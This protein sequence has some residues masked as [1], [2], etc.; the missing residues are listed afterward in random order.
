ML[1]ILSSSIYSSNSGINASVNVECP[2]ALK[3]NTYPIYTNIPNQIANFTIHSTVNCSISNLSG[4]F[5]MIADNGTSVY[6]L[7]I[8]KINESQIPLYYNLIFNPSNIPAGTYKTNLTFSYMH[9]TNSSYSQFLLNNQKNISILKFYTNPSIIINSIQTFYISLNNTGSYAVPNSISLSI[10]ITGPSHAFMR[11]PSNYSL[12]PSQTLNLSIAMYN[13]TPITGTYDALLNLSYIITENGKNYLKSEYEL[14]TYNVVSRSSSSSTSLPPQ[15][16]PIPIHQLPEFALISVPFTVSL[17]SGKSSSSMFEIKNT[18]NA[19]EY[20]NISVPS[21]Y[22]ELIYLYA[23]A[24]SIQEQQSVDIGALFIAPPSYPAG[25]YIIPINISTKISNSTSKETIYTIVTIFNNTEASAVS[26]INIVNN[27]KSTSGIIT[28]TNPT[29]S[30]LTNVMVKTLLPIGITKSSSDI[31][32]Y[33]LP[34]S[35]N[36]ENMSYIINWYISSLPSHSTTYGYFTILNITSQPF[37]M[38]MSSILSEISTPPSSSILKIIDTKIPL[39]YTN[40][41]N[42]ITVTGF[43]TGTNFQQV[44]LSLTSL[45]QVV[46]YNSTQFINVTPNNVFIKQFKILT[47]NSAGTLIFNFH[48][49]TPGSNVSYTLPALIESK[50]VITISTTIPSAPTAASI[51]LSSSDSYEAAAIIGTILIIFALMIF[52]ARSRKMPKYNKDRAERL[53]QMREAIKRSE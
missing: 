26:N 34:Y 46:I 1:I 45:S 52:I 48:A 36:V 8:T 5:S 44:T 38:H 43:Y 40:S 13:S 9:F 49:S 41:T 23:T 12:S 21:A 19:T 20:L 30:N 28:I 17:Q 16:K 10:N 53:R 32:A 2:F 18:G 35:I 11:I 39:F 50:P 47:G 37:L 22:S 4:K 51:T 3:L 14:I 6:S 27:T 33:G 25:Q 24:I 15:P 42:N 7:N 29:N 31:S